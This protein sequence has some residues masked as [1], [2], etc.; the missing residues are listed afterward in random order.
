MWEGMEGER[1]G[2]RDGERDLIANEPLG[3][4]IPAT[5]VVGFWGGRGSVWQSRP[6]VAGSHGRP[7]SR[8]ALSQRPR[9]VS[10]DRNV[11]V[12]P[13]AGSILLNTTHQPR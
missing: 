8:R 7:V 6:D 5:V 3:W 13:P 11:S 9:V 4:C 2:E 1:G 12:L 10:H